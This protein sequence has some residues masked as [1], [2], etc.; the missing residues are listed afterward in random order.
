[1]C[2]LIVRILQIIENVIHC[3]LI[4]QHFQHNAYNSSG[5]AMSARTMNV[6]MLA[7]Q[8]HVAKFLTQFNN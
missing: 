5:S 8:N 7:F 3:H 1:M 2:A 6:Q 4:V